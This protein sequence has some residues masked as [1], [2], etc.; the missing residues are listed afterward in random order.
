MPSVTLAE[1]QARLP[2]LIENLIP[3]DELVITK[4]DCPVAKLV[5]A[6]RTQWPSQ[7]GSA[8]GE[9]VILQD[10]DEHLKDFKEYME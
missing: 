2:E 8:V 1:A 5:R 4:D 7:P 10:D 3:G 6:P 9:L